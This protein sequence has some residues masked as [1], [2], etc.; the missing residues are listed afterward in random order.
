MPLDRRCGGHD[1][2]R[3]AIV[4]SR[5]VACRYRS[6]FAEWR[7]QLRKLIERGLRARV[8]V[9]RCHF[10]LA[11]AL[12]DVDGRDLARKPARILRPLGLSLRLA[13]EPVLI[14]PRYREL[15]RDVLRRLGHR[16]R[17]VDAIA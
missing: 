14:L 9:R 2:R 6:P 4:N 16:F 3:R 1:Q 5:S 12:R 10:R 11:P 7:G 15:G 13:R 8:L 17:A